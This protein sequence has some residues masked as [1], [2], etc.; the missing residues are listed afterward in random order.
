MFPNHYVSQTIVRKLENMLYKYVIYMSNDRMSSLFFVSKVS[1][2]YLTTP[3]YF[4]NN[5]NAIRRVI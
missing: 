4:T 1:L 3:V 5:Q 2:I